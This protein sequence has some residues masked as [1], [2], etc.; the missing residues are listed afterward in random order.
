MIHVTLYLEHGETDLER[1]EFSVPAVLGRSKIA[2]V[3]IPHPLISRKHCELTATAGGHVSLQDLDSL[4]GTYVG[5]SRVNQ[6]VLKPGDRLT[7]GPYSYRVEYKPASAE[8]EPSEALPSVDAD[9]GQPDT[10]YAKDEDKTVFIPQKKRPAED[11]PSMGDFR[12][13]SD[14][15]RSAASGPIEVPQLGDERADKV[16]TDDNALQDFFKKLP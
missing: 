11:D 6:V 4:N 7:L 5:K 9:E 15:Q 14:D 16:A 13:L 1:I 8:E 3:T 10:D 2:D 12:G